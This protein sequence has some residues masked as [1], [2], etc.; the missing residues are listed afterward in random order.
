MADGVA[1]VVVVSEL[2]PTVAIKRNRR[3]RLADSCV[4]HQYRAN[5]YRT[6]ALRG[7]SD[8]SGVSAATRAAPRTVARMRIVATAKSHPM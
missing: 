8:S 2:P 4:I 5:S 3:R 7:T 6:T 1:V